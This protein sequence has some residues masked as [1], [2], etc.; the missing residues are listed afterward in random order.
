MRKYFG[1]L[2]LGAGWCNSPCPVLRGLW[3]AS[4]WPVHGYSRFLPLAGAYAI[5]S[6]GTTLKSIDQ[7][8]HVGIL[9]ALAAWRVTQGI[10]RFDPTTFDA[11]CETPV[12]GDI[13]TEVLFRLPEWCVYIP[14]PDRRWGGDTLH[15]FFAHLEHDTNDRRVELRF[16]LD[17]TKPEG[18]DLVVLP[19]HLG[20]GGVSAGVAAMMQEAARHLPVG[21]EL[22][23]LEIE[24]L[25]R[26]SVSP[27]LAAPLPVLAGRRDPEQRRWEASSR[28]PA[29][30]E[31]Q[32][33]DATVCSGSPDVVGGRLSP[34]CRLAQGMVYPGGG[35][36]YSWKPRQPPAAHPAGAL[37]FVLGRAEERCPTPARWS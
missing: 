8:R 16:V 5:V 20:Q 31:D 23:D 34:R 33:R 2:S 10:Y 4:F 6:K 19:L 3:Q 21:A 14:T 24:E 7:T 25:A 9:G 37:A 11:L 28:P 1:R 32:E 30:N 13:P 12:T 18:E 29:A 35:I 15:G 27:G 17:L 22:P 36:G 26:R